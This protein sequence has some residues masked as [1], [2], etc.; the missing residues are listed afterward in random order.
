MSPG[1]AQHDDTNKVKY[2]IA[3]NCCFSEREIYKY[4]KTEMAEMLWRQYDDK[5]ELKLKK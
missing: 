1:F 3:I 4:M 5:E 2:Y